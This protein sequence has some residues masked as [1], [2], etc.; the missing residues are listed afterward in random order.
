MRRPTVL[1]LLIAACGGDPE[2]DRLVTA[3]EAGDAQ[4]RALADIGPDKRDAL[5]PVLELMERDDRR[6]VQTT[7][8][9]ALIGAGA[10]SEALPAVERALKA[11]DPP[12]VALAAL[13]HWKITGTREPGL[14]TLIDRAT[15]LPTDLFALQALRRAAPISGETIADD[16]EK[17]GA[18][19]PLTM[20]S[21]QA[22]AALGAAARPALPQ[23]EATLEV[24]DKGTRIGAAEAYAYVSGDLRGAMERLAVD[25]RPDNLFVR[26][27]IV[28]IWK[29]LSEVYP[30]RMT[31]ELVRQLG[32]ES[33]AVRELSVILLGEMGTARDELAQAAEKDAS[34]QVRRAA[35]NALSKARE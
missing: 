3:L 1:L 34:P 29:S 2:I 5:E 7:C 8:L 16:L 4:G 25:F 27:R 12:V 10:G 22:L 17:L 15:A 28:A 24:K 21:L 33:A 9:E 23:I 26:Q 18:T 20:G 14:S 31:A 13:A 6:F 30:E 11:G 19:T 35:T 32:D